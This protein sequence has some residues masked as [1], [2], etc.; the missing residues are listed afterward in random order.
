MSISQMINNT[1]NPEL[2]EKLCIGCRSVKTGLLGINMLG[3]KIFLCH[4][5]NL[6]SRKNYFLLTK[7]ELLTMNEIL[8]CCLE[9]V[10]KKRCPC[11][12]FNASTYFNKIFMCS[13]CYS[14]LNKSG[15]TKKTSVD[16]LT[17]KFWVEY[18]IKRCLNK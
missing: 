9:H 4:D 6:I 1:N 7:P 14:A 3:K 13:V 2:K 5:C 12:K 16:I 10:N 15:L 18:C 8:R 17:L 11:K